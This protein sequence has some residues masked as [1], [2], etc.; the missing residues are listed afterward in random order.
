MALAT[1]WSRC[2]KC[3]L[4]S[5]PAICAFLPQPLRWA[6]TISKLFSEQ[7][8]PTCSQRLGII[9]QFEHFTLNFDE[10]GDRPVDGSTLGHVII[11]NVW[12]WDGS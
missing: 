8:P 5:A 6:S 10:M 1:A 4:P 2:S 11:P 9:G 12:G 7:I 3:P